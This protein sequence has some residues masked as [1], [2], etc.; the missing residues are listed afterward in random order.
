MSRRE[1]R[2]HSIKEFS[3]KI[4]RDPEV[5]IIL[6]LNKKNTNEVISKINRKWRKRLLS[7]LDM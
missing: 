7:E 4:F 6:G 1:L 2:E 5:G 3:E